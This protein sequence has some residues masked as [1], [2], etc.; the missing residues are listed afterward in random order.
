MSEKT[1]LEENALALKRRME[2]ATQLISSLAGE[3]QR[4]GEEAKHFADTRQRL[5]GDC[6]VA[7]AFLS[8]CG[9]FNQDFRELLVSHRFTAD[10]QNR[11]LPVSSDLNITSFLV[12]TGTIG[13]WNMQGLPTDPLSIQNGL[14]VTRSS[15]YP[16]LIDPQGQA[17]SW[18]IAKEQEK[19]PTFSTTQLSNGKLRDQL[20]FC[21]SEGLTLIITGIEENIDPMLDPLLEKRV[22]TRAKAAY[23][24][25][26]D[27][28]CEL[29]NQFSLF[30]TTRLANPQFSPELFAKVTVIDFT[31]TQRGLEEQLLGRVIQN[32]QR[33][34]EDQLSAVLEEV[35]D[36]TKSLTRLDALLLERLTAN[37]GN[38][39][40]DAELIDVLADTKFKS[41]EVNEKLNIAAET[42]EVIREK[43]EQYRPIATRGSVL[44]FS[45]VDASAM[46][47]MYQTS[48]TQFLELFNRGM[49]H[50]EKSSLTSKRVSHVIEVLT[51]IVYRYVA[52]GLYERHKLSFLMILLSRILI[53]SYKI[54]PHDMTLLLKAGEGLDAN[55]ERQRPL[56][57]LSTQAWLNALH[58][59]RENRVFRT[60]LDDLV[61]GE[62]VWRQW[63][64]HNEPERVP[65]PDY[66]AKFAAVDDQDAVPFLRL[67]LIRSLREDC[68]NLAAIECIRNMEH[69]TVQ[70]FRLPCL[71]PEYIEPDNAS[72]ESTFQD[73]SGKTPIIFLLSAGADPTDSI[74]MLCRKKKQTLQTVSMGQGQEPIAL[75]AIN[76][77]VVNGSWVLLQNCHLGLAFM[78]SLEDLLARVESSFHPDFRLWITTEP[79]PR[80]PIGLLQMSIKVTNEPPSGLKAGLMRSYSVVVDQDKLYRIDSA[81][82]RTLMFS[83]C[84][85]HSI[86]QERRKYGPLG[87]CVP[88]EFNTSDLFASFLFLERHLESNQLSWPTLQYMVGEVH[89]GGRITDEMDRRL[90]NAYTSTLL[91]PS[92]MSPSFTFN[93]DSPIARIPQDFVYRVPDAA[94]IEVYH[95]Y[96]ASFPEVDSPEISGL[97]PNADL[98]FR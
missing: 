60:L 71:G 31:V 89:Y 66:E 45:I 52:R 18:I 78:E 26:S 68:T 14:L 53:S 50:A 83:L 46:N 54:T 51:R 88:Y 90:F 13:D 62:T 43:R 27:K 35:N 37:T 58:I 11:G 23:V 55:S 86:V 48:L 64:E 82:W 75:K 39:L 84:F 10:L 67:L 61:R 97:H 76:S 59:S 93:P 21:M 9:P 57:W 29:H 32:E 5:I 15:R 94:E 73:S 1:R 70:G 44:Y 92:I 7:S 4:W 74:E 8:Y 91:N 33:S 19:L 65:I 22:I 25:L 40:D 96:I 41:K 3:R 69:L 87:W 30:L 85:I 56:N 16:L 63:I 6:A 81:Q 34:L 42:R 38:L 2:Q 77:G 12:D 17:L 20:E 47:P 49:E 98:T 24:M 80:F 36:N 28:M 79:H 72:L 95:Q